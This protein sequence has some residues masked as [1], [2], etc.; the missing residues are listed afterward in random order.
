MAALATKSSLKISKQCHVF[1]TELEK[2]SYVR[3]RSSA[4]LAEIL[5]VGLPF[6][7]LRHGCDPQRFAAASLKGRV[8]SSA[9]NIFEC[10]PQRFA[11]ASLKVLIRLLVA[12]R[13]QRDPQRFAAASLKADSTLC[14]R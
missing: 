2:Y 14:A 11:A 4:A 13:F 10:D 7:G 8:N 3:S 12:Q 5:K 1:S 9:Q 6:N